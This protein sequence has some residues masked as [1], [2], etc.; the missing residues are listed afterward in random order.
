MKKLEN[1][2]SSNA[3][4]ESLKNNVSTI[5]ATTMIILVLEQ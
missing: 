3:F 1:K 5:L 4:Q 2:H